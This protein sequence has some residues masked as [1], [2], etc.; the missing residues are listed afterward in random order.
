VTVTLIAS[1]LL[2]SPFGQQQT[3]A[4]TGL[5]A[6]LLSANLVIARATGG[7]FNP[8]A[9][10]N[11]LLNTWSL[12]VEE[13]FY[14]I[15]PAVLLLGWQLTRRTGLRLH[16]L[17]ALVMAIAALSLSAAIAGAQG[18]T[19]RGSSF[20]LG[21]YS[22]A[23]RAWEFAVGSLVFLWLARRRSSSSPSGRS[24]TLI[25]CLGCLLLAVALTVRVDTGVVVSLWTIVPVTA[26]ALLLVSGLDPAAPTTRFL[27]SRFMGGIGDRSYSIYLWHWPLIVFA[28]FLWPFESAAL[29][30]AAGVSVVPALLSYKFVERPI[31]SL[32]FRKPSRFATAVCLVVVPP[33][34]L[35]LC[36]PSATSRIWVP[37]YERGEMPMVH[38]ES[39][40]WSDFMNYLRTRTQVCQSNEVQD[41][42]PKDWGLTRC[43]ES[44][45]RQ[46]VEL[47]LLGDSHAEHLFV[48]FSEAL[49]SVNV[50]YYI[51]NSLPV[52]DGAGVSQMIRAIIHNPDIKVVI[53]SSRWADRGVP[54]G[55]LASVLRSIA[56]SG[57]EVF[58]LDDIPDFPFQALAC[59]YRKA[60][61]IP[62]TQCSQAL[63][64]FQIR[65]SSYFPQLFNATQNIPG[66]HLIE[67]SRFFC[68][69][70]T[71]DMVQDDQLMYRDSN[72][73]NESGS[74]YLARRVISATPSLLDSLTTK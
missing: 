35:A 52:E 19:F 45:P 57:K 5:G 38:G 25:G 13:Q 46:D 24:R 23:T 2:L 54:E 11:P 60:P 69:T 10:T 47:V 74:R 8:P 29:V 34:A 67:T 39:T 49:P 65:H 48:G 37:L 30:V 20:L 41:V 59:K 33:V 62:Q 56:S 3:A 1:F 28:A 44:L 73:L 68:S 31:R 27:S 70:E 9:E 36:M 61:L 7:Y 21:F 16:L 53:V 58:V 4:S 43:R 72:H 32:Q 71:C 18:V 64:N 12:S 50:A 66:V 22:P 26:T 14:L 51:Q 15:F 17:P 40:D 63:D 6:M 42:A 55:E